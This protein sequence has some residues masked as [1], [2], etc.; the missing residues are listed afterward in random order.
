MG[1]DKRDAAAVRCHNP[2]HQFE[3]FAELQPVML[4]CA[5]K[6]RVNPAHELFGIPQNIGESLDYVIFRLVRRCFA[7]H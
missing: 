4:I 6:A 5:K 7:E 2:L 1:T 3:R